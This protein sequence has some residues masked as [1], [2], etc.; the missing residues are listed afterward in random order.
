[1]RLVII[2]GVAAG[3]SAAARAR[4]MDDSAEIIILEKGPYVSFANCGLP[5]YVGGDIEDRDD[6]L[7]VSPEMFRDRFH[8]DVRLFHEAV[9][10]RRDT[11]TVSVSAPGGNYELT[12]DKLILAPGCEPVVPPIPGADLGNISTV[13]TISDVDRIMQVLGGVKSAVVVGGGFIGIETA[14]GLAKRGIS[15]VL[16]EMCGQLMT[17]FD[18]EIAL[19]LRSHLEAAGVKVLLN[20]SVRAFRGEGRVGSAELSDGTVL[21]ADLDTATRAFKGTTAD[22]RIWAA[23]AWRVG[24]EA[25]HFALMDKLAEDAVDNAARRPAA[26]FQAFLNERF[27]KTDAGRKG[28]PT[29]C[30]RT[31]SRGGLPSVARSAQEG[32]A[33]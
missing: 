20:T 33:A 10:I 12:Y 11:K 29:A 8:I 1:M 3:A 16:V 26:A 5:Y 13:F 7:L 14:E 31:E 6:L 22:R 32:G 18:P 25:F 30:L 9:D 17:I 15:T 23:I 28:T 2:G 24:V 19:P 4:R 27:P 21:D